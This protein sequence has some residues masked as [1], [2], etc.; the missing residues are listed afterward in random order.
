MSDLE[1]ELREF[2][3][4]LKESWFSIK[5]AFFF[6]CEIFKQILY[7][8]LLTVLVIVFLNMIYSFSENIAGD[9]K[10]IDLVK[11]NPIIIL[12]ATFCLLVIEYRKLFEGDEESKEKRKHLKK[13]AELFFTSTVFF[14]STYI[15]SLIYIYED[16]HPYGISITA[17]W[18]DG[19][20]SFMALVALMVAFYNFFHGLYYLITKIIPSYE[21]SSDKEEVSIVERIKIILERIEKRAE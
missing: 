12:S 8:V 19:L 10:K 13:S 11:Y 7:L 21:S 17:D 2:N 5:Y 3:K 20:F 1:R 4:I 15:I 6:F 14:L 16:I 18:L 9:T